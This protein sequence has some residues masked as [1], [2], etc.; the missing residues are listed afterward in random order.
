[1]V[2]DLCTISLLT[3]LGAA[4]TDLAVGRGA[5]ALGDFADTLDFGADTLAGT[6][7][8]DADTLAFGIDFKGFLRGLAAAGALAFFLGV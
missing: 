4:S 2:D 1:M 3:G 6:L 5:L 8:L 7:A